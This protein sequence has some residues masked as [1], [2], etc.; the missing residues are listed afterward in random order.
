LAS[1]L[2]VHGTTT[3]TARETG[4][5]SR[6]TG[7]GHTVTNRIGNLGP[8][9]DMSLYDVVVMTWTWDQETAWAAVN[10]GLVV[11]THTNLPALLLATEAPFTAHN[12]D[13]MWIATGGQGHP[14]QAGKGGTVVLFAASQELWTLIGSA[15]APGAV[16]V[17]ETWSNAGPVYAIEAG[18]ALATGTAP[19]RRVVN[20]LGAY[21]G[22]QWEALSQDGWDVV[23]AGVT[24]A[25]G[26]TVA[27]PATGARQ[28]AGIGFGTLSPTFP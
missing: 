27:P 17:W 8:P 15:M 6:L 12:T 7:A 19:A 11:L 16:R 21:G 14:I 9:A 1:I 20:T 2:F 13:S 28:I 23:L 25:A 24:W 4:T 22:E 18:A 26:G 10:K 3:L 5:R